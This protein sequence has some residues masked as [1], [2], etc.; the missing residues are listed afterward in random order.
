MKHLVI[1]ALLATLAAEAVA[2]P[3]SLEGFKLG[4]GFRRV[5][6]PTVKLSAPA[7][8]TVKQSIP[9]SWESSG[10]DLCY[11]NFPGVLSTS[12]STSF[13]ASKPT[14]VKLELICKNEFRSIT[15]SAT[16]V[17]SNKPAEPKPDPKPEPKPR[18]TAKLTAPAS[19]IVGTPIRITWSS[20]HADMC[21]ANFPGV[22]GTQGE[23]QIT[24]KSATSISLTLICKN[25][26]GE[27]SDSA[28]VEVVKPEPPVPAP[29]VEVSAPAQ[30]FV[31]ESIPISWSSQHADMCYS[32]FGGMGTSG[33]FTLRSPTK[34]A[35]VELTVI[36]S[37]KTGETRDSVLVSVAK[38]PEPKTIKLSWTIPNIRENEAPLNAGDIVGYELFYT[39][40]S[41][42]VAGSILIDGEINT[43]LII[44]NFDNG[45][46]TFS[47]VA[48]D[49][50]GLTSKLSN[51]VSINYI[52]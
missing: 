3:S 42:A 24:A 51:A 35:K 30:I 26:V 34:P 8:A 28:T 15:A 22:F 17:I 46:Y 27:S 40:D 13:S 19:G 43:S 12:G 20:T 29:S 23:T 38:K 31:G 5:S 1:A 9:V 4:T 37:N 25:S 45:N 41:G 48:I 49:K 21:F 33:S 10:A 47:I 14:T 52:K 11:A 50:D 36:C 18:P 2:L 32:N 39:D 6:V 16:V 7:T 44:T